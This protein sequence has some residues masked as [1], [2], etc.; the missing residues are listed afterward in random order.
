MTSV[1][2]MKLSI[3]LTLIAHPVSGKA[4]LGQG[5][6]NAGTDNPF[7]SNLTGHWTC[8][9]HQLYASIGPQRDDEVNRQDS[10][11]NRKTTAAPTASTLSSHPNKIINLC[12]CTVEQPNES[13]ETARATTREYEHDLGKR[14][15]PK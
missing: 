9:E 4:C 1:V 8:T 10:F 3:V 11:K 7:E 15:A 6:S 13:H 5:V 14:G 12:R 2:L